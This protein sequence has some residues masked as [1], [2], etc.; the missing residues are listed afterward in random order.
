MR[1]DQPKRD[2]TAALKGMSRTLSELLDKDSPAVD[3][4]DSNEALPDRDGY[5]EILRASGAGMP[6][7]RT[8]KRRRL[9]EI[10][11]R[12]GAGELSLE[13]ATGALADLADASLQAA[14]DLLEAPDSLAIVAMGKLGGRELNYV[15]DIDIMFVGEGE[16][17][18]AAAEG[19]LSS[20]GSFSPEGQA[21]F[22]DTN[23]RPEGRSGVLV[24]SLDSYLEYYARWA[25]SWEY[26]A[27]I[28]AR[29]AAGNMELAA[30]LVEATRKFVFPDEVTPD[31]VAS[32]R[33]MKEKVE[34]HAARATRKSRSAAGSDV[35]LGPGGI[36]DIEF[37]VQLLQLVH[38][39]SDD[40][41]RSPSTLAALSAL[42]ANG[43]VAEEDEAGLEVAYRWLR[44]IEH[45]LQLW[46][47]RRTHVIPSDDEPRTRLARSMGFKDS[48]LAAAG[49]RF[50]DMHT[51]VLTDVRGRFERIFYRPMI[52]ALAGSQR[53][54][55]PEGLKD[56]LRF[57][58]FRNVDRAARLLDDLSKSTSR[59][60]KLL[61][62]LSPAFLRFLATTPAPDE[63]LF[64]FLRLGEG[65]PGTPESLSPLRENPPGLA[66]LAQ[67]LGSGRLLGEILMHVPEELQSIAD[68]DRYL[69]RKDRQRL[70][71]E[72]EASLDWREPEQRRDGLRRVKR[73]E[74]LRVSLMDLSGSLATEEVGHALADLADAC[75]EAAL[76]DVDMPFAVIGMGK[77]GGRELNYASDVDVMFVHDG[78]P[79]QAERTAEELLQA[80]GEI[81]PE[82]QAFRV[83]A[84]LRPE[85]KAGPLVRSLPSYLE[86]YERWAQPWEHHA[87]VKARFSA[88]D[89][90][91]GEKLLTA[92]RSF[93]WPA[94]LPD[95]DL[96]EIR[97]LKARMEKERI[98]RR[99]DPRRHFKLGPGG[100]SDVEFAVQLL[101]RS[102]AGA[103]DGIRT[104][105]TLDALERARKTGIL[106]DGDARALADAYIF[107]TRVRNRAF[108]LSGRPV[109]SL[110]SKTEDLEALG[111]ALGFKDQPRQELEE[112]YL[113]TTRRARR[114]A[115][116]L[117][118]G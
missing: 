85:G 73:R 69:E 23:L 18:A 59:R 43:Y 81:T 47:E 89:Q 88:G 8:A 76:V 26:Q 12:D 116:P 74:M 105:G 35:K 99:V 100:L 49:K 9:L 83:D 101:Q 112:T 28:K 103:G 3:L 21:Y 42:S 67:V 7:V 72:V 61:R 24:R 27:L 68:P 48:P 97:H 84:A 20:L 22:I 6:G 108:F 14:L 1:P 17:A 16:G 40:E 57:L 38:G 90:T 29:A 87:L 106:A 45:R 75:L 117:I 10:A 71:R 64:A 13:E 50:D 114:V 34:S 93:A 36:R 60:V 91:L 82:G 52:E 2:R 110:P 65:I 92:V 30:E 62:V 86:Y 63:G 104:S 32:V 113:R 107:L 31:R 44:S 115:E 109:D 111:L 79:Q 54:L 39:G 58:G 95:E 77:L 94:R 98:G 37:C 51:G 4:L 56:R 25:Q 96:R 46:Q 70:L 53:R 15:S 19:L 5:L 11:A 102:N 118:Y 33:A 41:V 66:F 55:S 78:D 80:V